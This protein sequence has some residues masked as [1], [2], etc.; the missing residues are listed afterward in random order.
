M[1]TIL[2]VLALGSIAWATP[3]LA[4]PTGQ[5]Q[6]YTF[7][8]NAANNQPQPINTPYTPDPSA[9]FNSSGGAISVTHT[10]I[11]TYSVLCNGL[12][13][14]GFGFPL[15]GT[16]QVT[17]KSDTNVY[18]HANSWGSGEIFV[19]KLG[20]GIG[21]GLIRNF[22]ATVVCFGKGGGGGGGPAPADSEFTLVFIY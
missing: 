21:G 22:A 20:G 5:V 6:C 3:S 12:G 1:K 8:N 7:A 2:G 19:E 13:F 16:V 15:V 4:A 14:G 11:G 10:G 18:C 17:A 9:S